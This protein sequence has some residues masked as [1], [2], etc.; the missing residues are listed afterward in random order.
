MPRPVAARPVD[1]IPAGI[2]PKSKRW[3]DAVHE[4]GHF[5]AA[6]VLG[7]T[8]VWAEIVGFWNLG[9]DGFTNFWIDPR[10]GAVISLVGPFAAKL[11]TGDEPGSEG[12]YATARYRARLGNVSY[13][14]VVTEAHMLL[15]KHRGEI[16]KRAVEL[17]A[18]G[19]I[20]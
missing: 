12:D 18:K 5:V 19:R 8:E 11:I 4:A 10:Y 20:Q 17:H 7:A 3:N 6:K 15:A 1:A 9:R 13:H 16:V 2:D 14:Q